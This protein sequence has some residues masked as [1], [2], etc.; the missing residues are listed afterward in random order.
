M[1]L[2][3]VGLIFQ[4]NCTRICLEVDRDPLKKGVCTRVQLA[5]FT[6]FEINCTNRAIEVVKININLPSVNK[7]LVSLED[8]LK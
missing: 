2:V 5:P 1:S 4:L 3:H 6:F 8:L 7:P